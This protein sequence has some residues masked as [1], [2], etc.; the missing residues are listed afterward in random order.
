[1]VRPHGGCVISDPES[2][3]NAPPEGDSEATDSPCA[4]H[5]DVGIAPGA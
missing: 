2:A 4:C 3:G 1:M 5:G